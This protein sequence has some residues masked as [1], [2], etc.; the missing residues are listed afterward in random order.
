MY[1]YA[2]AAI[3][4]FNLW[5]LAAAQDHCRPKDC[6]DLKCY[7][8][9]TYGE[10]SGPHTIY[11]DAPGL[12][13]LEVSCVGLWIMYQRRLNGA[14]NFTRT[15]TEYKRHFGQNGDST[16]ELWL[17]NENVYALLQSSRYGTVAIRIELDDWGGKTWMVKASGVTMNNEAGKYALNWDS[18]VVLVGW[19]G[20]QADLNNHKLQPFQTFDNFESNCAQTYRGGW[21]YGDSECVK[22]FM[23]GDY[24]AE[25]MVSDTSIMASH[26]NPTRTLKGSRMMIYP[27]PLT[28]SCVNPCKHDGVCEHVADPL[29]HLCRCTS[30]WCGATCEVENPCRNNA[31]C[32]A[33]QDPQGHHC[34]CTSEWCGATCEVENP[35]RNGGI[36]ESHESTDIITCKC[37][38]EF[39]GHTCENVIPEDMPSEGATAEDAEDHCRPK[40]CSDLKCYKVSTY[41]ESSGP[42]TIYP[43][44]S[45]L[46][47]L[48]VSCVGLWIMYQRRLN[49]AVNFTR[50]WTEYKRH[51]GQNGDS[52]TELWLGN[53]NVYALLQ[54]SR[55]GTVEIR[56]ELDDWGGKTWMVKAS[57]VTM[58]NEA[59]KYAL[60]W[61]SVVI[62]VGW[63]G[64]QA[65]LN[66]HKL[67]PFQTFDNFES[68]CAQTYRGGWWYG[69]S[70]CVKLFMNGDY[71]AED[72]VSD[73]SIMASSFN[74]TRT[75]KGS[76]MMIYPKP[77]TSSCVNPCKHD[78]VCEHVADPLGHLCRCTSEW[79]GAT[80]EVENPCR[81][82]ASCEAVQDPQGH[83]C[84][85]TS[86]WCGA[87][88]EVENPCRN[89]GICESHESTDIITCK[90][91]GEF[92]GHTC[93]NVIPEDMPSEGATAEDAEDHCRPKDC[94]DLKCYKVST[95]GESSGPHT[96]YPDAPGLT[97]LE[98][99]CFG[100]WIMYQR[101]VNGA[102]NFTRTWNEYKRHFGQNGDKSTELWLG[103]ENVYALLQSSRYG[104]VE[105]RIELDDW[106]GNTWKVKAYGV[107][108]NNEAGKY[109][110]NWD[111]ASFGLK[112][113]LNHHKLQP[114]QTF[115]KFET[116]CP[117]TYRGGWWYGDS[118]CVKLFMNGDYIAED[119]VSDTSIMASSFKPTRT[120]KG[121]RMMIYPI[122]LTSSCVNP[123]K[124]DGVCE[125][126]A[127]PLGHHC[128]C[129]SEWCGATCEVEKSRCKNGAICEAAQD[130]PGHHCACTS[131]WC[132]A[133]CE[134]EN[135]CRNGGTCKS[136]EST[137]IITCKCVGEFTGHTCEDAIPEDMPSEGATAEDAFFVQPAGGQHAGM[138][139][140]VDDAEY[141]CRPKDCSDLMC[142]KVSKY[143]ESSGPHTIYPDAPGLPSLEVS[144]FGLWIMYQRRV[145]GAVNFTRTWNEYK[146]HFGQNGD[147]TTE[148][149]LGNENVYALLQSS[150]YGKVE[151]R[152]E[153][154][155]WGGNTWKVKAYAVTMNNEAGKYA[156]NWDSASFGLKADLYNHKLQPFQTFDKFETDCPQTYRGGWWY[157]DSEC[158][159][160]FMNGDYIAE[161][162]VSDTSIMAS[163][164]KPTR[165]LKGSRMMIY[166]KPLTSSCV[167]PCKHDG[168]CEHVA[169]PLGHHC[170]CT[171]EWCGATCEVEKS[172][173]KNNAS[174]EAV[175]DPPGH[176]CACTSEWCGATCEVENPCRNNAS[177]EAVE[178]PTGHHCACTS[179]WCGATCE[180]INPCKNGAKCL[181]VDEPTGQNCSCTSEWCGATCEVVNP[182]RNGGTCEANAT[183]ETTCKCAAG[184]TGQTCDDLA[185]D[186][187]TGEDADGE[188]ATGEHTTSEN[189]TGADKG[190][191]KAAAMLSSAAFV[192]N[193]CIV[194][195]ALLILRRRLFGFFGF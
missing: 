43:D 145:N 191:P 143:E 27:K 83:H 86:E 97:S 107:T 1:R 82:N 126:V 168:V 138:A 105:I 183:T 36:C 37:V 64:L 137:E 73:T 113:D 4:S 7:K 129:T 71:I 164:F 180:E 181:G 74:P 177:C 99:S 8:V 89:G 62:L 185:P 45:G 189:K 3:F 133:T 59:G 24:I 66:N 85:C 93:E 142:Y 40:D 101:R 29:G 170:R 147:S 44:A 51:F 91:V 90:C 23:N 15:W 106:G 194:I 176:H 94:S 158:V 120:L 57:G 187:S 47:S 141:H 9:S 67:Q 122:P 157:G 65:D 48:E 178:D 125:H 112:D 13:S 103:N 68:N 35:C 5:D 49:G 84:A 190:P 50:T 172:R 123:C 148:L 140:T 136:H 28:S 87:T 154:D 182:C 151:I 188:D 39:T 11:P 96:I 174:C 6:S 135:P 16:T 54:S 109:A 18:V 155:D 159:K 121:S 76:R 161:D 152:I 75:L 117:Q 118:E 2:I 156:L 61:D 166:P 41:G 124:H 26:F 130:P 20:L 19:S 128:R 81:N 38:G 132:G 78:G 31:S 34:A 80:C 192:S 102:V 131:E 175:Q 92:T 193:N 100:L 58:N 104:Q 171:S 162:M 22:L 98:V 30:E 69:D 110:L 169:D 32:E 179:E 139:A 108:M 14:V 77:L 153:L 10:S 184:F 114:F 56:I 53:E 167:N 17:G 195:V 160:L 63:G 25:D 149:W 127:D 95:Y 111:L 55:Y 134:V 79:C 165:T 21:W 116:D 70:E 60:N 115:D 33:V 173:C 186:D 12:T 119:M 72:M 146:R 163:S 144:C 46:A 42:H 150:R 52:T 88:C